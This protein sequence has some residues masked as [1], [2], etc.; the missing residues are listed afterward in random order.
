MESDAE[1]S[2]AKGASEGVVK[3]RPGRSREPDPL[4]T[5]DL[6]NHVGLHPDSDGE[7]LQRLD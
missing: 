7:S 3:V 5:A 2:V 4:G 6:P 1:S